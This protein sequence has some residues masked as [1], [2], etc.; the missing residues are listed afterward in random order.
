MAAA[1]ELPYLLDSQAYAARLRHLQW[2]TWLDSGGHD[3]GRYDILAAAPYQCL[4]T[5]GALTTICQLNRLPYSSYADPFALLQK[6]LGPTQPPLHDLPFCGGAIGFWG[7]D[8][9]RRLE[10]L[11]SIAQPDSVLPDMA[12][13]VYDWAVVVDHQRQQTWFVHQG[14]TLNA[15]QAEALALLQQPPP[16]PPRAESPIQRTG[17]VQSNLTTE[18]YYAA[19]GLIQAYIRAG[20]CYQINFAQRFTAPAQGSAWLT[21]LALRTASPAPYGAL[22]QTPWGSVLSNSPEQFLQIDHN[23][24]VCTRPIKG[25]RP[26]HTDPTQDA[27]FA[28]EL[29]ASPKDRAEN[30]MI[31]DLLRNDLSKT[32]CNVQVP[33]LCEL[34]SFATVHHLISTIQAQL[35]PNTAPLE[36]LKQCFPGGSITGAPKIRAMEII[37]CLEPQQRGLYCGSIGYLSFDGQLDCN[38]SIRTLVYDEAMLTFWGGG[39]I[40]ADSEVA[41][42]YQ[43]TFDKIAVW[44]KVISMT[45]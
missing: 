35:L 7:Y 33:A 23:G 42:E 9:A 2:F 22:L 1:I 44:D 17:P 16:P 3:A 6:A 15:S 18:Q 34:H 37:E 38:I 40:V 28:A 24:T 31:V 12:I 29:Q 36:V 13:A 39:G 19:F 14:Q 10:R 41:Q 21:Y 4:F 11:P 26:R 45:K 43:E 27:V 25:T 32:C 20:D 8:L 5:W 30:V